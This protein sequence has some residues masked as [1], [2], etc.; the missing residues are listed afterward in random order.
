MNNTS[1]CALAVDL[2]ASSGRV[3]AGFLEDGHIQ[4]EEIHR[5]PNGMAEWDGA[6]RWDMDALFGH[7]MEGLRRCGERG[8]RPK[9]LGID[10]WGVDYALLDASGRLDGY[11]TAYRDSRTAGM[12]EKLDAVL[13]E[14]RMFAHTGIAHQEFNTVYQ[15]MT[16]DRSKAREL[17]FV[18][19]YLNDLLCG[20]RRNEYTIAST[21]GL[22]NAVTRD[23]DA[24]VL[25]AA[26]IPASWL[27][28]APAMPGT[29][30]GPLLPEIAAQVG[31]TCDV[32]L[33]AC[34]DT[35][36]AFL[37]VPTRDRNAAILSSGTWSL[38]GT[39]LDAPLLT[40]EAWRSGFTNE[41]GYAGDIRFLQNIMGMWLLQCL[42]REWDNR[43][44]FAEMADMAL[45]GRGYT[46]IFDAT[47][48]E[49]LAPENMEAA[50]R[51]LLARQGAPDPASPEEL[52]FCVYHS[53]AVCYRDAIRAM[54]TMTGKTFASLH[55]VGGGCQNKTLNQLTADETG[56]PVYAGPVEGTALGNLMAQWIATGDLKDVPHAREVL[57]AS[58]DILPYLPA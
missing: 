35:G 34:H 27:G 42:R 47:A 56:L 16:E 23:W 31:F 36:S 32:V 44:T 7:I 54:E 19:C 5:F 25:E 33:P 38:L 21:S 9:T 24:T 55:I 40:E 15:L 41:G 12:P 46:A 1:A 58:V 17:I 53:L 45:N 49:L 29:V 10:T 52:L 11:V 6:L 8:L 51:G 50:I 28:P 30:L 14:V 22:L 26:G 48:P 2:G 43:W 39:E 57:A 4:L 37:A 13:P 20:V 18:P 3:M